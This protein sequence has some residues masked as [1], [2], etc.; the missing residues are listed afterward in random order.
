MTQFSE[1]F[2]VVKRHVI[3]YSVSTQLYFTDQTSWWR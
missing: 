2:P 1:R 3:V